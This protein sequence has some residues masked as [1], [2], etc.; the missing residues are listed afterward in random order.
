MLP[1]WAWTTAWPLRHASGEPTATP[2]GSSLAT[3]AGINRNRYIAL[4][5]AITLREN[6][7]QTIVTDSCTSNGLAAFIKQLGGTHFRFRKGYKN[8][9]N[10][11]IELNEA[12]VPCPLMMETSGHGAMRVGGR[13]GG[14]WVQHT[15]MRALS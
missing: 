15:D 4:M 6:P 8:I 5:S 7:G 14:G 2:P 12:G 3:R 13:V 10:K 9:I 11:G 1:S